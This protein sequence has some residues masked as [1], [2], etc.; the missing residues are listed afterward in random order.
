MNE[1]Q[2]GKG[3]R[4]EQACF[5]CLEIQSLSYPLEYA[6]VNKNE[7]KS[8]DLWEEFKKFTNDDFRTAIAWKN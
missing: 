1:F 3:H 4:N 8:K 6:T 7:I 5:F 2:K